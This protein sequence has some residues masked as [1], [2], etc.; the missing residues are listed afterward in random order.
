MIKRFTPIITLVTA[1]WVVFGINNLLW[2]GRLNQYGIIP[3]Q[4]GSLTG[5]LWAPFL[6]GSFKHLLANT[7]PL[8]FLG[9]TI[10]ARSK[11]EFGLLAVAGTLLT[12]GLTWLFAR[13][14]SHIGASGLIFC[15]FGYIASLALFRRTFGALV[16]SLLC[17]L[18]YGGIVKG[19]VPTS[20]RISWES[21]LAGL[22]S[23]IF[24]AWLA[25]KLNP[26]HETTE[27]K[28]SELA[29]PID[30]QTSNKP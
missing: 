17:V 21:H 13:N 9:G 11:T 20:T 6:H 19:I 1:C 10:C 2:H 18:L 4:L 28:P 23:G 24:L 8:L 5:I 16:L 3:H 27:P 22:A 14:A 7:L 30:L 26:R 29:E 15:F 12:G 25:S